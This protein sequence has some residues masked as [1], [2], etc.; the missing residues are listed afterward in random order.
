[1]MSPRG[2]VTRPAGGRKTGSNRTASNVSTDGATVELPPNRQAGVRYATSNLVFVLIS[3]IGAEEMTALLLRYGERANIPLSLLRTHVKKALDK[4]WGRLNFNKAVTGIVPFLP[5]EPVHIQQITEL[6]INKLSSQYKHKYWLKLH[7]DQ[8][9]INY[10]SST[11]FISYKKHSLVATGLANIVA[12]GGEPPSSPVTS[13]LFAEFGARSIENSGPLQDLKKY[14]YRFM[15]PWNAH[16]VLHVGLAQLT[17]LAVGAGV[18]VGVSN[19]EGSA[20]D[21]QVYFQ[22]CFVDEIMWKS[23]DDQTVTLGESEGSESAEDSVDSGI[24]DVEADVD[25]IR[26]DPSIS[27]S[28]LCETIWYG[29]FNRFN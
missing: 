7:I 20:V 10:L 26:M 3:D 6:K 4:Q 19:P 25:D 15:Q 17:Q 22:W 9:L 28:P 2:V 14:L 12:D 29:P 27:F 13:K 11:S 8:D 21:M 1:M 16:L 18:G 5:L 23:P 24:C